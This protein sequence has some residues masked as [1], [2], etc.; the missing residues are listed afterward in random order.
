MSLA[1]TGGATGMLSALLCGV[2]LGVPVHTPDGPIGHGKRVDIRIKN[3]RILSIKRTR[4]TRPAIGS[5]AQGAD[6]LIVFP[7]LVNAHVHSNESFEQGAYDAVPLEE[8]LVLCYPPLAG[9]RAA[10]RLDYLRTMKMAMQSLQSGVTALHDDFLNPGCDETR[11]AAVLSA[12]ADSGIRAAVA[13]TFSDRRYLDGLPDGRAL[14]SPALQAQLDLQA[15]LPWKA[16]L[17][18]F[19]SG[20]AC[21]RQIG[22][23]RLK[24]TLGPRGPQRC[25]PKLMRA[26]A[27]LSAQHSVPVHMHVLETRIQLLAGLRQHGKSL[28][29][30]LDEAGLLTERLTMNHAIWLSQDDIDLMGERGVSTTHLPMS[31]FKLS[32]GLSPVKR[33]LKA[34]INVALGS[35]GPATG[36]SGDFIQSLRFAALAHKL[37]VKHEAEAPG[38]DALVRMAT[39]AGARSMGW[40]EAD[41]SLQIGA[42]ADLT[43]LDANN[44][45]FV[46]LNHAARQL[47]YAAGSDAVHSVMVSGEVVFSQGRFTRFDGAAVASEIREAAARF[48]HDVLRKRRVANREVLPFIRRVVA[49]A[50]RQ[51][52]LG[53]T[54][55]RVCLG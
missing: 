52:P 41:G 8:W 15:P 29:T 28:V 6:D 51:A 10:P 46:P 50:K 43:L 4:G 22:A 54:V 25:T 2:R 30:V 18:Q 12:Y 37:D 7:G 48:R 9:E 11:M 45:A 13:S 35:D 26:I 55:N 31:N 21:A 44:L 1:V 33:L 34:G 14:C 17:R 5:G 47:C 16:Q 39:V 40:R 32:S 23:G 53:T 42:V 36:D 24:V 38:A 20:T 19:E 49:S 3:G 27:E